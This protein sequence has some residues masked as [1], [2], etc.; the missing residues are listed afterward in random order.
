MRQGLK[1]QGRSRYQ[2][3]LADVVVAIALLVLVLFAITRDADAHGIEPE[4]PEVVRDFIC[5]N[6]AATTAVLMRA[7][8][9]GATDE[10]VIE[11]AAA[12][13]ES[14]ENLAELRALLEK[15]KGRHGGD[16][17]LFLQSV[18]RACLGTDV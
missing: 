12:P 4:Q 2:M 7:H 17:G 8:N 11:I 15:V 1:F 13:G 10:E 5:K 9:Y 18:Y 6:K 16:P 3:S 14:E